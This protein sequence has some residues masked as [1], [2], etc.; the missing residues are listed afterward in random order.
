MVD[1]FDTPNYEIHPL[2]LAILS[3]RD[4]DENL[5]SKVIEEDVEYIVEKPPHQ[6]INEACK[7]F[8]SSLKGRQDGTRDICGITHKTPISVDPS[9]GMYFFPTSS[10][11]NKKCSWI[12]HSHISKLRKVTNHLTEITFKSGKALNLDVSYGI[13]INQ[14]QR[15]AQFRY[16][17]NKRLKSLQQQ[18]P[19]MVAEPFSLDF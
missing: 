8:G 4:L 13:L 17:L 12:A 2:T 6:V 19:E 14:V 18:K 11:K 3:Y 7:Y 10:P 16:M 5:V 15:T 9:S 1:Y